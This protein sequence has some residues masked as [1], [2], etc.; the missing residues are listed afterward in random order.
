MIN[1]SSVTTVDIIN[2]IMYNMKNKTSV[3]ED[4]YLDSLEKI[5]PIK[6]DELIERF[7]DIK[8]KIPFYLNEAAEK[9][10]AEVFNLSETWRK[11]EED[12]KKIDDKL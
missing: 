6:L 3:P 10:K 7:H 4:I 9:T 8:P 1:K 2:F 12:L 5:F 11:L